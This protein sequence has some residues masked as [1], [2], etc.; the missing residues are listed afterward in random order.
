[1]SEHEASTD[2]RRDTDS[3]REAV[4]VEESDIDAVRDMVEALEK[5][6]HAPR[7]RRRSRN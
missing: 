7:P 4:P 1:M 6:V 3:Y 2:G 5:A